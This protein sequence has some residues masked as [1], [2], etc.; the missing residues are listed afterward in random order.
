[1]PNIAYLTAREIAAALHRGRK[2]G[3][4]YV[5]SCPAHEDRNPSLSLTERD[6][7]ILAHCHAGCDQK[8]VV[9]ALRRLGLWPSRHKEKRVVVAQYDYTD[10][11]GQL[12][13]QAVRTE[14]KGFFRRKPDGHGGW[15]HRGPQD[16]EKVLYHLREVLGALIVFLA[17]GEKDAETLR[18]YGFIGTTNIGGAKEKWLPQYT[19]AL[20]GREV[21]MVPDNDEPGWE[22]A[23]TIAEAL[24]DAAAP[25]IVLELP[26]KVKDITD[27]FLA[28]HSELELTAIVEAA[29]ACA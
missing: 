20:R 13:Y 17:E 26:S 28:G 8:S 18:A 2:S 3:A 24:V 22:R 21:I 14:P 23:R 29:H 5:A 11:E 4:G 6:G 19:E 9:A 12:L 7:K 1:M 25:L 15:I 27:W 10:A 16:G